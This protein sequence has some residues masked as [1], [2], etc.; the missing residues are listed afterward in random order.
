MNKRT[1][2]KNAGIKI[3]EIIVI[4]AGVNVG[5]S[6]FASAEAAVTKNTVT[7]EVPPGVTKVRVR[8]W[9]PDGS[10][11]ID[12]VL[13]VEPNQTFRIDVVN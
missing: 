8:S 5:K 2:F 12:R 1:F 4:A 7:W 6:M 3:G 10:K 13:S 9:N 11:D